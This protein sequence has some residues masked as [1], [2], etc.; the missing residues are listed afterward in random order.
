MT[1]HQPQDA[2]TLVLPWPPSVNRLWRSVQGRAI[3]SRE[4]RAYRQQ[5]ALVV[6]EQEKSVA[7]LVGRLAVE[8]DLYPPDRRRRDIDN[9]SKALL[10]GLTHAG[11]WLDDSLI[12]VL[13]LRRC[14]PV[15]VGRV[16]VRIEEIECE[17]VRKL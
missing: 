5:V 3:L 2:I 17:K 16:E 12:D 13:T 6:R 10:D 4:G 11:V 7:P 9:L 14:Q 8:I 15:A 1:T